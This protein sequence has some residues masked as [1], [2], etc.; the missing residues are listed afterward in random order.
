[1]TLDP[2][3]SRILAAAKSGAE[4]AWT[5]IYG[6]LASAVTTY[7][8]ARGAA[9]PEDLASETF[10]QVARDIGS[11]EG[12]EA[13]FR[14]W[15]FV[16]A[17]RRLLDSWR[18]A[19]R[20]PQQMALPETLAESPGGN[21]EDEAVERLAVGD[22]LSTFERLTDDQR[23]VLTLRIVGNFTLAEIAKMLGRRVGA[24]KALQHRA[25]ATLADSLSLDE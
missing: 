21:T 15:V 23:T 18:S 4:W 11:F 24:I 14:S 9:E 3:F 12:T 25:L 6:D 10:L 1:M 22:F 20:R 19:G 17:H 8:A 5:A 7:L 2:D 13:G 16:I